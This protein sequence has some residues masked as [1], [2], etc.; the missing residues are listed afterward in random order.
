[1]IAFSFGTLSLKYGYEL[2]ESSHSYAS[3]VWQTDSSKTL[4]HLFYVLSRKR[5]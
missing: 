1:M 3:T 2:S 4:L 5:A